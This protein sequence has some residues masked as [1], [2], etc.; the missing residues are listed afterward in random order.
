M[1]KV[2]KLN[3]GSNQVARDLLRRQL[4]SLWP[5]IKEMHIKPNVTHVILED[6]ETSVQMIKSGTFRLQDN[7]VIVKELHRK[8]RE[9][10]LHE[11]LGTPLEHVITK[12][13]SYCYIDGCDFE[14]EKKMQCLL[15][16]SNVLSIQK[17]SSQIN[18]KVLVLNIGSNKLNDLSCL[19]LSIWPKITKV[20][21]KP[22][23]TYVMF[24]TVEDSL[25]MTN[26]C[27]F[28]LLGNYIQ[29]K[30]FKRKTKGEFIDFLKGTLLE[31]TPLE[32]YIIDVVKYIPAY[33]FANENENSDD[34]LKTQ[35][36]FTKVDDSSDKSD[37]NTN[38]TAH[39]PKCFPK[40]PPSYIDSIGYCKP[41][42]KTFDEYG[43]QIRNKNAIQTADTNPSAQIPICFPLQP[44]SYYESLDYCQ[45][46]GA[47]G[48]AERLRNTTETAKSEKT[49]HTH[50][51]SQ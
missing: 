12:F 9:E 42:S 44:P 46:F 34:I 35:A 5:S 13:P 30:E 22:N 17:S 16:K 21:V 37:T 4:Q 10:I 29:L 51:F 27:S 23:I 11:F 1:E 25:S 38:H 20:S 3:V 8:S 33:Y 48:E 49:S 36:S 14:N 40:E 39:L 19:L 26:L 24:S 18:S 6:V 45:T 41:I 50:T 47:Y 28:Y 31:G 43:E 7:L 15:Q 32:D 2:F